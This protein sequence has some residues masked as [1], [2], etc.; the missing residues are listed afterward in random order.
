MTLQSLELVHDILHFVKCL[1]HYLTWVDLQRDHLAYIFIEEGLFSSKE[2]SPPR[3]LSLPVSE[4]GEWRGGGDSDFPSHGRTG[5]QAQNILPTSF[6]PFPVNHRN[7]TNGTNAV[8]LEYFK[9][10]KT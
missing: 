4:S 2:S 3:G 9:G 8:N 1:D 6:C 10:K 5:G 7:K